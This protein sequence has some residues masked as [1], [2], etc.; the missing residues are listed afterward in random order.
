[1]DALKGCTSNV[2]ILKDI[3]TTRYRL[4][5]CEELS[6]SCAEHVSRIAKELRGRGMMCS[7][8]DDWLWIFHAGEEEDISELKHGFRMD[9]EGTI[10]EHNQIPLTAGQSTTS[11]FLDA[12]EGSVSFTLLRGHNALKLSLWT[13]LLPE[14]TDHGSGIIAQM[15]IQLAEDGKKLSIA[16]STRESDFNGIREA[17]IESAQLIIAPSGI[18]A[19]MAA[20]GAAPARRANL[21]DNQYVLRNQQW[22]ASVCTALALDGI[23]IADDAAWIDIL[24]SGILNA[25]PWP[26]SLCFMRRDHA[27]NGE[28]PTNELDGWSSWFDGYEAKA[29]DDPLSFAEEW[30]M[31]FDERERMLHTGETFGQDDT[32]LVEPTAM[33]AHTGNAVFDI[34]SPPLT[35][36]PDLQALHGIYPTPPDGLATHAGA[37]PP[38]PL[39]SQPTTNGETIHQANFTPS[40]PAPENNIPLFEGGPDVDGDQ[41][42]RNH[43]IVSSVGPHA[44]DWN[45]GSTDDLFGEM[46]DMEYGR[47]EVGDADFNFFDEP[48]AEP[49]KGEVDTQ[50][51]GS[52]GIVV[53]QNVLHDAP[54]YE[55]GNLDDTIEPSEDL[56]RTAQQELPESGNLDEVD[57]DR[58]MPPPAN[59]DNGFALAAIKH[60]ELPPDAHTNGQESEDIKPL[61]PFGI[62]EALLPP[63]IPAS[64]SHTQLTTTQ[65]RRRSSF[66]PLAFN[67]GGTFPPQSSS[68]AYSDF[69]PDE[70][71]S[72]WDLGPTRVPL[73]SISESSGSVSSPTSFVE[74]G[75][76]VE[77]DYASDADSLST[78][79]DHRSIADV[80]VEER[81]LPITRKR[82]RT[83]ET[84]AYCGPQ[85]D[86]RAQQPGHHIP[87]GLSTSQQQQLL[88]TLTGKSV[89][90]GVNAPQS[91]QPAI[92]GADD[93]D[94]AQAAVDAARGNSGNS[95]SLHKPEFHAY[96]SDDTGAQSSASSHGMKLPNL[97]PEQLARLN[98]EQREMLMKRYRSLKQASASN[99]PV[100]LSDC[101]RV[102]SELGASDL[103]VL[104]QV[105]AE[106]AVTVTRMVAHQICT[107]GLGAYNQSNRDIPM[108]QELETAFGTL[109]L[110]IDAC[111]VPSLAL[112]REPLSIQRLQPTQTNANM[113]P[114]AARHPPRPPHRIDPTALGPDILP[115]TASFIRAQ[116]G[117]GSWEM[118]PTA[119]SFWEALGLS[120]VSGPKDIR[121]F[122]VAPSNAIL[123]HPIDAYLHNLKTAYES[124][125][126]GSMTIG[127]EPS[128]D[129]PMDDTGLY[130]PVTFDNQTKEPLLA[131]MKAY[132]DACTDLGSDLA[133][134][135]CDEPTRT[136][137]VSIISPFPSSTREEQASINQQLGACFLKLSRAYHTIAARNAKSDGNIASQ[138]NMSDIDFKIIPIELVASSSGLVVPTAHEM[139]L[140][141]RE[142]YDRCPPPSN[143]TSETSPLANMTAPSVEL[144]A[145]L[146]K[147]IGFQLT[148]DPPP[149]LLHE[150][151]VLHVAYAMSADGK[152]ANVMWHDNTGR[153]TNSNAFCLQ[154]RSFED[155]AL[156]VWNRTMDLIKARQVIWR[157]FIVAHGSDGIEASRASC[158]KD[159]IARHTDRKQV[160]SVTLLH[161][162][163]DLALTIVPPPDSQVGQ[164]SGSGAPTPA[165]TPQPASGQAISI[166]SPDAVSAGNAPGTAPPTPA[167]SEVASGI[168]E[169]DS[170]AHLIETE[171]ETWG[172]LIER[173]VAATLRPTSKD[174]PNPTAKKEAFIEALAH[175]VMIKRGKLNGPGSNS[176]AGERPYPCAGASLIWTLRV[177]SK[178]DRHGQ[179][180][181]A[182]VDEGSARHAEV[183]LREVMGMF[184]NLGLLSK[185][186]GLSPNGLVPVHIATAAMGAEGLNGLL[187]WPLKAGEDL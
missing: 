166:T 35:N 37:Q 68:I 165:A 48:D 3:D 126:F 163:Q 155:I 20:G 56:S 157:I 45:R 111:D 109:D 119:L 100:P 53:E 168:L 162:Q 81:S 72:S 94:L 63:P 1:M 179:G 129:S 142:L 42:Q 170:E 156:E 164:G 98:P 143:D 65:E 117:D 2:H 10:A 178:G 74:V 17:D 130:Y 28:Y 31:T 61:S 70:R 84:S 96:S 43:S 147:R 82:K 86:N 13:W 122:C 67:L 134:I 7:T 133:A 182:V 159:V 49:V 92:H 108:L 80:K 89:R 106:Q 77:I 120:P 149:D 75:S 152:W 180:E 172:M 54:P 60:E 16:T 104:S 187:G 12:L 11:A 102:F 5:I 36:R 173:D 171:D 9:S 55:T 95:G 114:N 186:K 158:W 93:G 88:S 41:P 153:Y 174:W 52:P 39:E 101:V 110:T 79:S 145:P 161:F 146:P 33:N 34:S 128:E 103:A 38:V 18:M 32:V 181:R 176:T 59:H 62:R 90:V 25:V 160:L 97:S 83:M 85:S 23:M 112:V 87:Q 50:D 136:F 44:Q 99:T 47:E 24:P 150:A 175:G 137:L 29:Y 169:A 8:N 177:K 113:A 40:D 115:L 22:K 139:G 57:D 19:T 167:P 123:G 141:A 78:A 107:R 21:K 184:R 6:V 151:S 73:T 26:V 135:A 71:K 154:G 118:T 66:G 27:I 144:V 127:M 131:A 51:A 121:H 124:C 132:W 138:N 185:V 125:K 46:D 64:A 183:M 76:D 105:V 91:D 14:D 4:Y 30:A 58:S 116:R 69:K 15:N 140:I 148:S